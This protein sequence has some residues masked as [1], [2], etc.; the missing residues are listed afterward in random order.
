MLLI[1]FL[2]N[3]RN[4]EDFGCF[5]PLNFSAP[6]ANPPENGGRKKHESAAGRCVFVVRLL[7]KNNILNDSYTHRLTASS[8]T[9]TSSSFSP[10]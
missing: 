8:A 2:K 5:F 6:P 4:L 1:S 9:S 3:I 7:I 10:A